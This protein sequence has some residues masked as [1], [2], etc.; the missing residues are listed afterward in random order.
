[1]RDGAL[2]VFHKLQATSQE[3]F[4]KTPTPALPEGEG[5]F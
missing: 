3:P 1:M 5:A 2:R 4:S